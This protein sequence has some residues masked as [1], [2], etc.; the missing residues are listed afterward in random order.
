MEVEDADESQNFAKPKATTMRKVTRPQV[1]PVST[2]SGETVREHEGQRSNTVYWPILTCLKAESSND[3]S[4]FNPE[5]R[6]VGDDSDMDMS[7]LSDKETLLIT[8]KKNVPKEQFDRASITK[9]ANHMKKL[10]P[11]VS[12]GKQKADVQATL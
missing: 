7:T 9:E 10:I 12:D 4:D 3:R 8:K 1:S 6:N 2:G 11:K 5:V